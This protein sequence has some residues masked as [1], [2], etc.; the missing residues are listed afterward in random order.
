[1][2]LIKILEYTS[3][4][5]LEMKIIKYRTSRSFIW[6]LVNDDVDLAWS[7]SLR[8]MQVFCNNIMGYNRES[9]YI[10]KHDIEEGFRFVDNQS[11]YV[12]K[13]RYYRAIM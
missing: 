5:G 6:T 9:V 4:D 11:V 3:S 2:S 13:Y 1:M 10:P 8:S 7:F 12:T